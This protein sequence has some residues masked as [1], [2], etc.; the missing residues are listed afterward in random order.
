MSTSALQIAS[1]QE[2]AQASTGPRSPEGKRRSALNAIQHGLFAE[3]P[4]LKGEDPA[5]Y[6]AHC[7]AYATDFQ[8]KGILEETYVTTIASTQWRLNRCNRIEQNILASEDLNAEQQL[9]GL[10][11]FSLYE[12]RLT[13]KFNQT[14]RDLRVTQTERKAQQEAQLKEA[15][16]VAAECKAANQPFTA[17]E[18]GFVFSTSEIL[19][20]LHRREYLQAAQLRQSGPQRLRPAAA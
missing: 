12:A 13:R 15:V 19:T 18:F 1:N 2:N 14:L 11:R 4:I 20:R 7:N 6:Q 16:E 3:S 8:P 9:D 17:A 10:C 5:A